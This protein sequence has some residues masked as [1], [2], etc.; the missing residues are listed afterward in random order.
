MPHTLQVQAYNLENEITAKVKTVT[1]VPRPVQMYVTLINLKPGDTILVT[2]NPA[3]AGTA[4]SVTARAYQYKWRCTGEASQPTPP[5]LEPVTCT[6]DMHRS[7][8]RMSLSLNGILAAPAYFPPA[9]VFTHTFQVDLSNKSWGDYTLS[10]LALAT[11]ATE[12]SKERTLTIK[13]GT[14]VLDVTREVTRVGNY[15]RVRLTL[16]NTGTLPA[17]VDKLTDRL[18]GF[19][20]AHKAFDPSYSINSVYVQSNRQTNV[21]IDL[22][23]GSE[24]THTLAPGAQ[25]SVEYVVVPRPVRNRCGLQ[26]RRAKRCD[27]CLRGQ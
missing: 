25:H 7:V 16:K 9:G 27:L 6:V 15:Y 11:D 14:A 21:T 24:S 19:Q 13:Q 17:R 26:H 1:P 10:A 22:K 3:P 12:V 23:N 5:G 8:N 20:V 4:L 2:S 18:T